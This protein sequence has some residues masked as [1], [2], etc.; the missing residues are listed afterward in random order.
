MKI[1][2]KATFLLLLV[3]QLCLCCSSKRSGNGED[4]PPPTAQK[5][6]VDTI[7]SES[8]RVNFS[9]TRNNFFPGSNIEKVISYSFLDVHDYED[10]SMGRGQLLQIMPD[11][12]QYLWRNDPHPKISLAK[13]DIPKLLAI[14]NDPKNYGFG[15]SFCYFPRNCFCFYNGN[16]EIIG[17]YEICFE[18]GRIQAIPEF[19]ISRKGGLSEKGAHELMDFCKSAGITVR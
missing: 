10:D 17:F 11:Y 1:G 19:K 12:D 15:A 8:Q 2:C 18:C 5:E 13:R 7:S 9:K 3:I 14:I 4:L 6:R 16:N